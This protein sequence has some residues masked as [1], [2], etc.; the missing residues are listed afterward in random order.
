MCKR[1]IAGFAL[2]LLALIVAFPVLAQDAQ[3]I[4]GTWVH[5]FNEQNVQGQIVVQFGN[6][7]INYQMSSRNT[8][9]N[10]N[11]VATQI[12]CLGQYGYDGSAVMSRWQPS[13]QSCGGGNCFPYDSNR[14]V[15]DGTCAVQWQDQYTFVD[16][17][18]YD[19]HRH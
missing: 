10:L 15:S 1:S 17:N 6:G 18:G 7:T 8:D 16:C 2:A 11:L 4:R 14:V 5:S 9:Q 12:T 13:C 3:D 19:F